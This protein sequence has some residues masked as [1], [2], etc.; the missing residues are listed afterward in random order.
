MKPGVQIIGGNNQERDAVRAAAHGQIT[1]DI[2]EEKWGSGQIMSYES[3]VRAV[4]KKAI[5]TTGGG[6]GQMTRRNTLQEEKI[7]VNSMA[8]KWERQYRISRSRR[9]NHQKETSG[10]SALQP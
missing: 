2:E 8:S 5:S 9:M 1:C 10:R 7:W 3:G 4:E 6:I